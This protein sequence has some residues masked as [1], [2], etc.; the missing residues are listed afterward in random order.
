MPGT[1]VAV[2]PLSRPNASAERSAGND[3][4]RLETAAAFCVVTQE[5]AAV[6]GGPPLGEIVRADSRLSAS[7]ST[8]ECAGGFPAAAEDQPFDSD[9][10]EAFPPASAR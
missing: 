4:E 3:G 6:R 5:T 10:T 2:D 7:R 8:R 1:R 9:K